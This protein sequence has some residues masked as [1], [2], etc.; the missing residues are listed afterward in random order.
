VRFKNL[1]FPQGS[2]LEAV[3]EGTVKTGRK[4]LTALV[5]VG[6]FLGQQVPEHFGFHD[7]D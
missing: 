5:L 3:G 7:G 2:S 6:E 4:Q 1:S